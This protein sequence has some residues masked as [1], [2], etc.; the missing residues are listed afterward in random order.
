MSRFISRFA[1][2][3][4]SLSALAAMAAPAEQKPLKKDELKLAAP[5]IIGHWVEQDAI[6]DDKKNWTGSCCILEVIKAT[7]AGKSDRLVLLTNKH[8]LDL[9]GL[10]EADDATDKIPEVAEYGLM[11]HFPSG[12]IRR[13][14]RF[15]EVNK[16]IDLAL[17]LVDVTDMDPKAKKETT[18]KEGTDFV[19]LGAPSAISAADCP[20]VEVGTDAVAVGSPSGLESTHTFGRVSALRDIG[21]VAHIQTDAAINHGNSGG[22]LFVCTRDKDAYYWVGI[23]TLRAGGITNNLGFA[24]HRSEMAA[25]KKMEWTWFEASPN[26]AAAAIEKLYGR[27]AKVVAPR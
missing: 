15:G 7:E 16:K 9:S 25:E 24:I 14:K 26:G 18:L 17:V 12:A 20:K 10:A 3:L 27:K 13:V 4:F 19:Q 23:N 22:P 2:A 8:C 1:V 11:I 6:A 21:G 5:T